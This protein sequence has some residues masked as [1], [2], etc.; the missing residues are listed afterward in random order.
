MQGILSRETREKRVDIIGEILVTVACFYRNCK[1]G[2]S[3]FSLHSKKKKKERKCI[4]RYDVYLG[5]K[6]ESRMEM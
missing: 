6:E 3:Y 2:Q 4:I 1:N 5:K